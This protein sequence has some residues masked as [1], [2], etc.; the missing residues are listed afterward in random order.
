[1][2][3]LASKRRKH[4]EV[5]F[6]SNDLLDYFRDALLNTPQTILMCVNWGNTEGIKQASLMKEIKHKAAF[7]TFSIYQQNNQLKD[8]M[9]N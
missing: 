8:I 5:P 3:D 2:S 7:T 1:M 9:S 6:K 4:I